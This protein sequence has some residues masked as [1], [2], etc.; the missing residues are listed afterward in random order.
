MKSLHRL[1]SGAVGV[2]SRLRLLAVCLSGAVA[3][4]GLTGCESLALDVKDVYSRTDAAGVADEPEASPVRMVMD[5]MTTS[6]ALSRAEE[7]LRGEGF[8][9]ERTDRLDGLLRT[10]P[11]PVP[12][13][14]EVWE[15]PAASAEAQAA[16]TLSPMRRIAEVKAEPVDA[17][18]VV[19]VTVQ[20]ERLRV[21]DR[22]IDGSFGKRVYYDTGGRLNTNAVG[23]SPTWTGDPRSERTMWVP[24]GRDVG[25]ELRLLEVLKG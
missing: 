9:I 13:A 23:I 4:G 15:G 16:A 12:V 3:L 18:C 11:A 2:S 1:V 8:W 14:G 19:T 6:E 5:G 7:M 22:R 24:A 10:L 17:G 21:V 20:H 25:L